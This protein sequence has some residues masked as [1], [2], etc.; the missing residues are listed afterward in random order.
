MS[1]THVPEFTVGQRV[2][3]TGS[4]MW[5]LTEGKEYEV[6]GY[7]PPSVHPHFTFPPYVT[8]MGD[9]DSPVTGHTYRF[10]AINQAQEDA[11]ASES[12]DS[13]TG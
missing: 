2:R 10:K 4:Y 8:V 3:A 6:I 1:N 12:T 5:S 9:L 7:T 13:L 11:N